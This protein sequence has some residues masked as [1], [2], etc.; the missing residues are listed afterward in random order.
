MEEPRRGE[1][2]PP[3]K[4]IIINPPLATKNSS[5]TPSH[6]NQKEIIIEWIT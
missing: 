3:V 6:K 1:Q 2:N 5:D 4:D